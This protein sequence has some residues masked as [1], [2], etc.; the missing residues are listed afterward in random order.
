[1]KKKLKGETPEFPYT[2]SQYRWDFS[3]IIQVIKIKNV[4]E[5]TIKQFT[6]TCINKFKIIDKGQ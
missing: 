6:P 2:V 5:Y 4:D 3:N 1:M